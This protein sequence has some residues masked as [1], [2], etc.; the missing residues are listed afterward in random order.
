MSHALVTL[1]SVQGP[2]RAR[3]LVD[4]AVRAARTGESTLMRARA[5]TLQAELA[6]RA[7]LERQAQTALGLAWYD[8]DA[9]HAADPAPTSFSPGHLRGFEGVCELYIGDP[10]A[11]HD[12]FARSAT[13]LTAPREQV[14][15][16]IVTTDQALA[17][18]RLGEPQAAAELLHE[19]VAAA[20]STGG[21]VP[22]LGCGGRGRSC[23]RGGGRIGRR[24]W[25]IT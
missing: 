20:S 13:A 2:E 14:Q 3:L 17:R 22:A 10:A 7:G 21:R 5:H 6:A 16:A 8:M 9:D 24:T 15:R 1:Y 25:T 23:G 4:Q 12:R 18:I 11:A 19:C